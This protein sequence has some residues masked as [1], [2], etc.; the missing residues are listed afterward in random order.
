[1]TG[2]VHPRGAIRG[3]G[4]SVHNSCRHQSAAVAVY[5]SPFRHL[6]LER[7]G[8]II[9]ASPSSPHEDDMKG[10]KSQEDKEKNDKQQGKCKEKVPCS[11]RLPLS[12]E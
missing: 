2:L 4:L 5:R 3:C 6:A 12:A 7:A 8:A 10:F 1:M 9:P 11:L